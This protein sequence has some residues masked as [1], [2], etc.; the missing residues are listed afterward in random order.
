MGS[1]VCSLEKDIPSG[2]VITEDMVWV[3]R[4]GPG[5]DSIPAK[6]LKNVIGSKTLV[7][8]SKDRQV[9]WS[10]ISN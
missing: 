6:D 3:K 1:G 2:T 8:I 9:K 4:P 10:E 7:N 5:P